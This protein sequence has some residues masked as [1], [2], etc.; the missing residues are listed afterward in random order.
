MTR[1]ESIRT[2][3]R[4]R[5]AALTPTRIRR[6]SINVQRA[7]LKLPEWMAARQICLYL[8]LPEE[9]QTR[10]LLAA[11][12]Q[13]GK[14]VLVP[15]YRPKLRRYGLSRLGPDA[16]LKKGRWNVLEPAHPRWVATRSARPGLVV[17]PGLAF[18]RHGGRLGHGLGYY[19]RL[20]A[21]MAR[22]Q[23]CK[24]GL[25]FD[26]QLV[27]RVPMNMRDIRLDAVVTERS[28]YRRPARPT[29]KHLTPSIGKQKTPAKQRL[30]KENRS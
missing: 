1:K 8:A 23:V 9:I 26:C 19:D 24:V 15:A 18:D 21:E 3:M 10:A 20:L 22:Q 16:P 29:S 5:C 11:C 12:W 6:A 13:T 30:I 25:A 7:L 14:Q 17:T 4:A 27:A 2:E 28:V